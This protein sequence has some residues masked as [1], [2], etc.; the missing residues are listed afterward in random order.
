MEA[1]RTPD[2]ARSNKR[3]DIDHGEETVHIL[4]MLLIGLVAGWLAGCW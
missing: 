3:L 4:W 1:E 2:A